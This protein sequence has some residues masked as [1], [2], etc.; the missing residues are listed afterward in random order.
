[1]FS[2]DIYVQ[3]IFSAII[4]CIHCMMYLETLC[5]ESTL[6]DSDSESD[7]VKRKTKERDTSLKTT[8][9]EKEH[10]IKT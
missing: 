3:S 4:I 7:Y 8:E 6:N 10:K 1:V 9:T 5:T 2:G